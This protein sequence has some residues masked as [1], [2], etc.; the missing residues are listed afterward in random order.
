MSGGHG[1][2]RLFDGDFG[3]S[4]RA[5][6]SVQLQPK[7]SVKSIWAVLAAPTTLVLLARGCIRLEIMSQLFKAKLNNAQTLMAPASLPR[8]LLGRETWKLL[9]SRLRAAWMA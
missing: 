5:S 3:S 8:L 6:K 1:S 7:D 4:L 9:L 2:L